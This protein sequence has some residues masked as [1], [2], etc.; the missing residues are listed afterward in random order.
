MSLTLFYCNKKDTYLL[1]YV[2]DLNLSSDILRF[3]YWDSLLTTLCLIAI[4]IEYTRILL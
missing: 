1:F 4:R 3:D 2:D